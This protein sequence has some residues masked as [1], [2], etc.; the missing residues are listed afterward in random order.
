MGAREQFADSFPNKDGLKADGTRWNVVETYLSRES[1]IWFPDMGPDKYPSKEVKGKIGFGMD[2]DGKVKPSDF[3]TPE[4][5]PGIDNQFY[6]ATGCIESY[7]DGSSQRLFYREYIEARNFNRTV[8]ELTNVDS[9]QND[10]DVTVTTYRGLDTMTKDAKGDFAVDATQ[11]EDGEFGRPF[12]R[13]FKAKI[14]N[15][16]L[17]ASEPGEFVWPNE[18]HTDASVELMRGARFELK[19]TPEHMEGILAGYLDIESGYHAM[20]KRYG[21]HQASYGKLAGASVY[22]TLRQLADG[23]PDPKTGENTA[24]SSALAITGVRV[25]F[26]HSDKKIA[27]MSPAPQFRQTASAGK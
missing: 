15:G 25:R 14:V 17:M 19:L 1:K 26:V 7:R 12:I 5:T 6:R 11:R 13:T 21:S 18:N 4:G 27:D 23:Y 24:I 9:L 16:T 20:I 8:I 3:T 22:K 10:D 2:L